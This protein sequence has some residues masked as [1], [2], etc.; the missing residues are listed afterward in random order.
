M[1]LE[2]LEINVQEKNGSEADGV[3]IY[4]FFP[5]SWKIT[6]FVL[7]RWPESPWDF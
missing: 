5:A 6:L 4:F 7:G 1:W 3:P 2:F